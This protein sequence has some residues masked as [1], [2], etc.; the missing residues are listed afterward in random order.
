MGIRERGDAMTLEELMVDL[1]AARANENTIRLAMNCFEL[2][3]TSKCMELA[4]KVEKMPFGDTA[5]SF[6]IWIREQA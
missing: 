6:A 1:K 5:A 4:D 2:G 3:Q